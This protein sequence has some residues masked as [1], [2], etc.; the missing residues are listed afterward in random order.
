MFCDP[1]RILLYDVLACHEVRV[2]IPDA[3]VYSVKCDDS[4][5]S[6]PCQAAMGCDYHQ[7]LLQNF[8]LM[9][10]PGLAVILSSRVQRHIMIDS[11]PQGITLT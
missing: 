7:V 11:M 3:V 8:T 5:H 4:K 2:Y 1:V 10:N 6:V 9:L